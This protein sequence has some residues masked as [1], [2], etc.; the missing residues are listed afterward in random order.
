MQRS[1]SPQADAP[2]SCSTMGSN[3]VTE[4]LGRTELRRSGALSALPGSADLWVAGG[5]R[6]QGQE[7]PGAWCPFDLA[8]WVERTEMSLQPDSAHSGAAGRRRADLV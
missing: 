2:L 4:H 3:K 8:D 5:H 6:K 1:A 7:E